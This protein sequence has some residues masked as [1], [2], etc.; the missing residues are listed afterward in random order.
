M[1]DILKHKRVVVGV[2]GGIAAY[3]AAELVR[4]LVKHEVQVRVVMTQSAQAFV[5]PVT[6]Q[7]L[8]GHPVWTAMFDGDTSGVYRHI[9]WAREADAAVIAPATAN[10]IGKMAMGI[11]DDPLTTL[12]LGVQGPLL[13]CPAMNVRM[14]ENRFVQKNIDHLRQAGIHIVGPETGDLACGEQ[15]AGRLVEVDV[16]LDALIAAL[17]KDDYAGEK[18]LV[19]AGPTREFLDPVRFLSNPSSGKMGYA[20]AMAARRR[21]AD[22][23]LVSGPTNLP[24]PVGVTTVHVTTTKDMFEAVMSRFQESTIIVKAAAVSD[25]RPTEVLPQKAKKTQLDG[26]WAF[27]QTEDILKALGEQKDTRILVGFAAETENI[28]KNALAKLTAKN[29]DMVVANLVGVDD[30]GFASNTNRVF[31]IDHTG[32]SEKLDLMDKLSLADVLLDRILVVKKERY[33]QKVS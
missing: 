20:V 22:V 16:I 31:V 19:T 23:V 5:G 13:V 32:H 3:K 11:A 26:R 8:C 7:A 10:I 33:S 6:F 15:G 27:E 1:S 4:C 17:K 30:S 9:E 28:E 18:L 25:W 12:V 2:S 24:S 21:G 29:L 14:Y